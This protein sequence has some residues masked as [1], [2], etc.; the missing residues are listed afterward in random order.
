METKLFYMTNWYQCYALHYIETVL[1]TTPC[2]ICAAGRKP[3]TA[4]S[5]TPLVAMPLNV[6]QPSP[7]DA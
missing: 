7:H 3:A 1:S 2:G 5:S 4:S 6:P